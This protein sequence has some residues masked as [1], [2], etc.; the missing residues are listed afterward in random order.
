MAENENHCV[1]ITGYENH[2]IAMTG[3]GSRLKYSDPPPLPSP[4]PSLSPPRPSPSPP[5]SASFSSF[6]WVHLSSAA[7]GASDAPP[8]QG[9]ATSFDDWADDQVVYGGCIDPF[10]PD[11]GGYDA[12]YPL[13]YYKMLF[14]L[15]PPPAADDGAV[16][17]Y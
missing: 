16:Y 8:R 9:S 14:R 15:D 11:D 10:Q 3:Y 6:A 7:S 1:P 2:V 4:P 13:A 5:P 17:Y 12:Y